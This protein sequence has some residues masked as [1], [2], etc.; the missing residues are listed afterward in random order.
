MCHCSRKVARVLARAEADERAGRRR[1]RRAEHVAE[2]PELREVVPPRA[3][4][5]RDGFRAVVPGEIAELLG[6]LVVGLVP[7]D[8]F[9]FAAAARADAAHGL[10]QTVGVV[11]LLEDAHALDAGVAAVQRPDRLGPDARDAAVLDGQDVHTPAVAAAAGG[12]DLFCRHKISPLYGSWY[13]ICGKMS[14]A[15]HAAP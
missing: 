4:D 9:P 13:R 12:A 14:I 11:H 15:R 6:D 2:A 1:V 10:R 3:G 8:W 5:E 7:A